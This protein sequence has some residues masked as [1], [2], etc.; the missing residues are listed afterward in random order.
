MVN[1]PQEH[2]VFLIDFGWDDS[3]GVRWYGVCLQYKGPQLAH[4]QIQIMKTS[5][6]LMIL[7]LVVPVP[8]RLAR[9]QLFRED[10]IFLKKHNLGKKREY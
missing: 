8:T 4:P 2:V 6:C 7:Y 9:L 3:F 10:S 5:G 1:E